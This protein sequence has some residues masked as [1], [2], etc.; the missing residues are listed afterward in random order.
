M[1]LYSIEGYNRYAFNQNLRDIC[2]SEIPGD[3]VLFF[4]TEIPSGREPA[5][6]PVGGCESIAKHHYDRGAVVMFADLR[7][8]FVKAEDFNNLRWQP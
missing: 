3:V 1:C 2:L 8:E 5:K 4:E 6:N 7:I